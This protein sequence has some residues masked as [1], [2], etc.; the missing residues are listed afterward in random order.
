MH[1]IRTFC[2]ICARTGRSFVG[3]YRD[4]LH[5]LSSIPVTP[6]SARLIGLRERREVA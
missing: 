6:N 2:V 1:V 5:E 3:R 4:F